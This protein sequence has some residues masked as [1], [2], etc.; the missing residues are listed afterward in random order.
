M[1]D[2]GGAAV[3]YCAF[4]GNARSPV[5]VL[6]DNFHAISPQEPLKKGGK[7][8]LVLFKFLKIFSHTLDKY[9]LHL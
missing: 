5:R 4:F 2:G 6:V 8:L 9:T 1:P 3:N 7:Y